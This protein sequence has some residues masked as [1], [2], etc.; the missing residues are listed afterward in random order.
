[1]VPVCETGSGPV[2]DIKE[3]IQNAPK[4]ID[5]GAF[6]MIKYL[7]AVS[8]GTGPIVLGVCTAPAGGH[9]KN[10]MKKGDKG[11]LQSTS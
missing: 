11:C 1:M 8:P 10:L 9:D 5:N 4:C 2:P 3:N 6:L 7:L